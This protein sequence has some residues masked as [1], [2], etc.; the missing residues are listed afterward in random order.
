MQIKP[1][2]G[3]TIDVKELRKYLCTK[4]SVHSVPFKIQI[5]NEIEKNYNYKK[6]R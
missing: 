3:Y 2:D 4:L 5:V 1:D 6:K